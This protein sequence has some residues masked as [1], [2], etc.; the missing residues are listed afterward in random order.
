VRFFSKEINNM[1]KT[2]SFFLL[3]AVA[4]LL[5]IMLFVFATMH[6][7]Q[8]RFD[9]D[10][11][12]Y[13][14][15]AEMLYSDGVFA[16]QNEDGSLKYEALRTPGYPVF[17]AILHHVMKIPLGG[18]I[19]FQVFLTILTALIVYKTAIEI[20]YK[21]GFLSAIIFL[22]DLPT[23]VVSLRFMTEALYVF[24]IAL[25]IYSFTEYFKKQ[26]I[27]SVIL[28]SLIL[29]A[30]TYVRPISYPLAG[31]VAIFIV[32]ANIPKNFKTAFLHAFVFLVIV[33]SLLVIWQIRNYRCCGENTF[34]TIASINFGK[35]GLLKGPEGNHNPSLLYTL[36]QY[37]NAIWQSFLSLMTR[38]GSLKYFKLPSLTIIG[39]ILAYPWVVFW[40]IGF[41]VGILRIRRNIYYQFMLFI[42][43]Y[44]VAATICN[45]SSVAG[46][47]FR[48]PIVPCIAIISAYGW[49][50]IVPF[51][52]K[53]NFFNFKRREND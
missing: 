3:V 17:I 36:T 8:S 16:T 46:E 48:V 7:P 44:F 6:A 24:L 33:Y 38:P 30:A 41:I 5:K 27:K 39:K 45:I 23:A 37:I 34:S 19:L 2:K 35:Y 32:Y 11:A 42:I 31:A 22:Y 10:S 50:A 12:D 53:R 29:A 21:I 4:I 20:D 1:I 26:R 9:A 51:I 52:K 18:V 47:R 49:S 28:S 25:F 40:T 43:L 13:L 15:T 14:K